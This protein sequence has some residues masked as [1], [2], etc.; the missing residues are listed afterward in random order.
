MITRIARKAIESRL[1]QFPAVTLVGP[2]QCGKTTLPAPIVS[3]IWSIISTRCDLLRKGVISFLPTCGILHTRPRPGG[4]GNRADIA[5]FM[6]SSTMALACSA[7]SIGASAISSSWTV[8]IRPHSG[9]RRW[10]IDAIGLCPS[11]GAKDGGRGRIRTFEGV[12]R[13]IYSLMQCYNIMEI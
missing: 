11:G 6:E 10:A 7:D 5:S 1:A 4:M 9:G 12:S 8:E 2:R 3:Q 13:Q